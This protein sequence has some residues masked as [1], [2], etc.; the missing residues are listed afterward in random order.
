LISGG[1]IDRRLVRH[2]WSAGFSCHFA[3][4]QRVGDRL[5]ELSGDF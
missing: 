1:G 4:F 5:S 2:E 3:A